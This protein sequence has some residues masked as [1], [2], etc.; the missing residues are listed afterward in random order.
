M[1]MTRAV[2][3]P[4]KQHE[5]VFMVSDEIKDQLCTKNMVPGETVHNE[6]LYSVPNEDGTKSEYRVWDPS[7]SDLAAALLKG[8]MDNIWIVP[9]AKV[10][11]IGAQSSTTI[12]HV[13]DIVGPSGLVYVVTP[14]PSKELSNIATRRPNIKPIVGNYEHPTTYSDRVGTV[15]VVLSELPMPCQHSVLGLNASSYLKHEGHF[16][17]SVK[18]NIRNELIESLIP[19]HLKSTINADFELPQ[20]HSGVGVQFQCLLEENLIPSQ[21]ACLK[22]EHYYFVGEYPVPPESDS[23]ESYLPELDSPESD[24]DDY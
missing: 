22:R 15:D 17:T 10:L 23:P 9:G 4:Y 7:T 6:P 13:S 1:E 16:V 19:E 2:V 5:G 14:F 20:L 21:H 11:Y 3:K 24:W 8:G 12:A 18:E